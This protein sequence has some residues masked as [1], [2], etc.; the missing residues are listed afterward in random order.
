VI[1]IDRGMEDKHKLRGHVRGRGRCGIRV[2]NYTY[3]LLLTS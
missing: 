3:P 1:E 2:K